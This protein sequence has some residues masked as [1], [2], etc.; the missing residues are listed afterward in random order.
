MA[1][2]FGRDRAVGKLT[3]LDYLIPQGLSH[4]ISKVTALNPDAKPAPAASAATST[5]SPPSGPADV[6][7]S[8][9]DAINA[10]H[11]QQAWTLGGDNLHQTYSQFVAGFAKTDHDELTIVAVQGDVVTVE[12]TATQ[13]DHTRQTYAGTYTVSGGAITAHSIHRTG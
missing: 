4:M 2:G 9:I 12:L 8:Y 5:A 7:R 6:V 1:E 13:S 3:G 10:R 11:Y